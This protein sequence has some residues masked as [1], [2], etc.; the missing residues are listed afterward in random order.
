MAKHNIIAYWLINAPLSVLITFKPF[1]LGYTGLFVS[2]TAAQAY[3]AFINHWIIKDTDWQLQA[4]LA[5]ERRDQELKM[6]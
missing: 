3:L 6:S 2:I 5:Q 1:N 4:D